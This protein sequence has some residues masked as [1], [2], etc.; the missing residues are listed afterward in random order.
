MDIVSTSREKLCMVMPAA[1]CDIESLFAQK[2]ALS[3]LS[4]AERMR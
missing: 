2:R 1:V 3:V 4:A